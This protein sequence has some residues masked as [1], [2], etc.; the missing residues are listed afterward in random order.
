M[1]SSAQ[2][3]IRRRRSRLI[4]SCIHAFLSFLMSPETRTT[5]LCIP[6][7]NVRLPVDTVAST[8]PQWAPARGSVLHVF[9]T[10]PGV[11]AVIVAAVAGDNRSPRCGRGG[12]PNT[13]RLSDRDGRI[14]VRPGDDGILEPN[15]L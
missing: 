9:Q 5:R 1:L 15:V 3:C 10:L 14:P 2:S 11:L 8:V 13:R 12:D 7:G 4:G 6:A